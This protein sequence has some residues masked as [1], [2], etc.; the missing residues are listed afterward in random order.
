MRQV[1]H[2]PPPTGP[3]NASSSIESPQRAHRGPLRAGNSV[4]QT[5]QIGTEERCGRGEPHRVQQAGNSAQPKA[6]TGLRSTRATARQREVSEGGTSNTSEPESLRKTHLTWGGNLKARPN[7]G[8]IA[9]RLADSILGARSTFHRISPAMPQF[10][11]SKGT[12]ESCGLRFIEAAFTL[13]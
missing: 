11:F 3:V 5:S 8:R 13:S 6:S 12:A 7:A 1:R 9:H 10:H 4:Q 2:N